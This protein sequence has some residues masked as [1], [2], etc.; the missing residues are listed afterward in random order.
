M[1]SSN[2]VVGCGEEDCF[3]CNWCIRNVYKK[4][5]VL[6]EANPQRCF[7]ANQKDCLLGSTRIIKKVLVIFM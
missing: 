4:S 2:I 6:G 5:G 7:E 3:C 1:K